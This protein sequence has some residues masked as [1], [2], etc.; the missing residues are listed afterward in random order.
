MLRRS[1]LKA[2]TA[3]PA[4]PLVAAEKFDLK[5]EERPRVLRGAEKY[6]KE[7]PVTVTAASSPRSA[8]GKHDYF[9][10]GDYWWPDPKNPAGP[11]V[12]RDGMS[13]PDNFNRHREA[14]IRLSLIVPSMAAAFVLTGERKYAEHGARHL[15]AWFID[16]DTRMKPNLQYAQ[17]IHGRFTGRGTGIID[18]LH[19]VEVARAVPRLDLSPN[20]VAGAK[21]WFTEYLQWMTTHPYGIAERDAKNNHGTCWVAQVAAFARL[22]GDVQLTSYC[23]DRYRSVLIPD[24]EAGDGSFP[25]ELARTKPYGYSL[26]NL[27]AMAIVSQTLT[28]RDDNL[29]T[30]QLPD[31]RG[32]A[33]AVAY[34][35]PFILDKSKWPK[36]ADVMYFDQWPVRQ[37]S[38]LFGGLALDKPDYIELWKKLD[39]DPKVEEVIRNWPVRQPVLWV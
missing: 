37:P 5:S 30:W 35:Y 27:D 15:R 3:I 9:S 18:T 20:D 31:G 21:K 17:A 6:L 29:W 33:R 39:A 1:F 12:Q 34:M 36:P 11:Y 23:R 24:Q 14:L 16:A 28:T 8:G 22:T 25:L 7:A 32:M 38:L 13:N 10:E 2:A 26:F 4:W 19:L